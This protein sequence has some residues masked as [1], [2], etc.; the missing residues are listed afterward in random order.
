MVLFDPRPFRTACLHTFVLTLFFSFFF[1]LYFTLPL[2]YKSNY[3]FAYNECYNHMQYFPYTFVCVCVWVGV[4]KK[5]W[6]R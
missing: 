3:V 4:N 6:L 2:R 5:M 1:S